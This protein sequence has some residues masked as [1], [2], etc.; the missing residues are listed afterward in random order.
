[1][2]HQ[3]PQIPRV[4]SGAEPRLVQGL[5][6]IAVTIVL[7]LGVLVAGH[8]VAI[9]GET[10]KVV[11]PDR[12]AW[13]TSYTELGRQQ[14]FFQEQGLDVEISYVADE[15]S[16][17]KA[18]ISGEADIAVAA[19][20]PDILAAWARKAPIKIISPEETGAPDIFWVAK[21]GTAITSMQDLHGQAVGF[22]GASS[23]DHL[24]LLTLLKEAGVDD[25][26]LVPVGPA[27]NGMLMVLNFELQASWGGPLPAVKDLTSGEVHL[28]GR[29]NDSTQVRNQTFR[30]NVANANFLASHRASVLGFLKAYKK[31]IDWAYSSQAA[32]EAYAKLADVSLEFA[33]YIVN[34][35]AT[36]EAAQLDE[37]KG[38]NTALAQA[39]A[40]KRIAAPLTHEDVNGVY[41]LVLKNGSR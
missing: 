15:A 2:I 32:L 5:S 8:C 22:S 10:I 4:N 3:A 40:F 29:G 36:K 13:N 38:E 6:I 35:F 9:A 34:G 31:T 7:A 27:D 16:L 19:G 11:V 21:V 37:I 1:V 14:G 23:P 24:V 17:E 30:V 33:K 20:F 26:R 18:L 39:L 25:A 28:I 41:D 12:G